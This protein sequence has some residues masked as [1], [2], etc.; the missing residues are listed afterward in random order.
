MDENQVAIVVRPYAEADRAFV[1]ETTAKVRQPTGVPWGEWKPYGEEWVRS[2]L[3]SWGA[4]PNVAEG[5]GVI[6]GFV[7]C[8]RNVVE[9]LY[10]KRDYRGMGLGRL[11]LDAAGFGEEVLC[12]APTA[13]WRHWCRR[14][15]IKFTVVE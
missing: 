12:R 8:R 3:L 15:G 10:V 2:C 1:V 13:S 14:R 5:N 6:L 4:S 11:L 9:V 7:L